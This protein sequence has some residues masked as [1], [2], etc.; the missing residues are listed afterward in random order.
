MRDVYVITVDGK[1]VYAD[2]RIRTY[3]TEDGAYQWAQLKKK[4]RPNA[5]VEVVRLSASESTEVD[6]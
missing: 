4:H 5:K 3:V 1:P 6:M 2:T